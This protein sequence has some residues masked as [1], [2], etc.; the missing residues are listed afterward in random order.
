[1][2]DT[3]VTDGLQQGKDKGIPPFVGDDDDV[4]ALT[5]YL[6]K[7]IDQLSANDVDGKPKPAAADPAN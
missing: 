7:Q 3:D 5:R 1:M 4:F 2:S 6:A